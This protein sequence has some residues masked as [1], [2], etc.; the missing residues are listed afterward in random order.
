L[1]KGGKMIETRYETYEEGVLPF[2][3][4]YDLVRTPQNLS[5]A[6]NWHE[7]LEIQLCVSGRGWVLLNGKK[8]DFSEGDVAVIGSE[9]IHYTGSDEKINYSCIIINYSYCRSLDIDFKN[10]E[11]T[12]II[13]S[14]KLKNLINNLHQTY[15]GEHS[16]KTALLHGAH[17]EIL[18]EL[19]SNHVIKRGEETKKTSK[20]YDVVKNAIRYVRDNYS[21]KITLEDMERELYT[22]KFSLSRKFKNFTGQ[23]IVEYINRYRVLKA[24]EYLRDGCS[25]SKTAIECG[26]DNFSFFSKTFKKYVGKK[27]SEIRKTEKEK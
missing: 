12:P 22:S 3:Y 2:R 5:K 17:I 6:S 25:V 26:F 18:V 11:F 13:K 23:T 27:P 24:T 14:E 15:L 4:N 7:D 9:V 20:N 16:L 1:P 10:L 19:A 8:Y 21:Q